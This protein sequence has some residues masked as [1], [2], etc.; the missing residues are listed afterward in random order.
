MRGYEILLRI[1]H[2]VIGL[3]FAINPIVI[4][5]FIHLHLYSNPT[6]MEFFNRFLYCMFG[7][8]YVKL[9]IEKVNKLD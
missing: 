1:G 9:T 7:E 4:V 2:A 5:F 3:G 6:I 8:T